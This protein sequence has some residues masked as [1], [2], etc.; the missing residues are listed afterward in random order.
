[1]FLPL[2]LVGWLNGWMDGY[3]Y[4]ESVYFEATI[5]EAKKLVRSIV[6]KPN[7]SKLSLEKP[8]QKS[9]YLKI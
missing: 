6:L 3:M 7:I 2:G 9:R 4:I 8:Q 1:M 5:I